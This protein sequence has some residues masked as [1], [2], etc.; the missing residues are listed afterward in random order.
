MAYDGIDQYGFLRRA[1]KCIASR[2]NRLLR[3][4]PQVWLNSQFTIYARRTWHTLVD[5]TFAAR[6]TRRRCG[7]TSNWNNQKKEKW[8]NYQRA[9]FTRAKSLNGTIVYTLRSFKSYCRIWLFVYVSGY[10]VNKKQQW[11]S[12][13]PKCLCINYCRLKLMLILLLWLSVRHSA[14]RSPNCNRIRET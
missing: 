9:V 10:V 7:K 12:V 13:R 3:P 11:I 1:F 6:Q 14:I 5:S 8:K 2:W 4:P